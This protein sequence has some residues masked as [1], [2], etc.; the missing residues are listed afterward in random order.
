MSQHSVPASRVPVPTD[1]SD[2]VV[3][4]LSFGTVPV[5]TSYRV[6][7]GPASFAVPSTTT[8]MGNQHGI[9]EQRFQ[10]TIDSVVDRALYPHR[11]T[12]PNPILDTSVR[13]P[14]RGRHMQELRSN[15]QAGSINTFGGR[16]QL[17][18]TCIQQHTDELVQTDQR[19]AAI[20][21]DVALIKQHS[22]NEHE[23]SQQRHNVAQVEQRITELELKI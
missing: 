5:P 14:D 23:A 22:R 11:S 7:S 9:S 21:S 17:M 2:H 6:L 8:G 16:V 20:Q 19:V 18:E 13:Q 12:L 4:D 10:A 15:A 3:Q 1:G